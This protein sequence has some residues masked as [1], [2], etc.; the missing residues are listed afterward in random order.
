MAVKNQEKNIWK[1]EQLEYFKKYLNTFNIN[2]KEYH[3]IVKGIR[4]LEKSL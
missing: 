2:S 3:L 1:E 4:D